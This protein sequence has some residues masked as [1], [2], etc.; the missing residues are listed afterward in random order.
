MIPYCILILISFLS[1]FIAKSKAKGKY[2]I[3][4]GDFISNN[5]FAIPVFFFTLWLLLACRSVEVGNDT[6]NYKL[7]FYGYSNQS[8]EEIFIGVETLFKF[9][10]WIIGKYTDSY[11]V[12]LAI[13]SAI[14][15]V[16]ILALYIQDKRHSYLK[17]ILFC[18]MSIFVLLFSG[19]RQAIALSIGLIAFHF[20]KQKKPIL[21]LLAVFFAMGFHTSSFMLFAMYPVYYLKT[22]KK[23]LP[24]I[25]LLIVLIFI[26]NKPIFDF[27]LKIM[28]LFQTRFD[29]YQSSETG[30]I[31]MIILFVIFTVFAY[32]I[33]DDQKVD[34]EFVG[35]RNYIVMATMLQCFAPLHTLAMRMNYYYI[36]FL[37]IVIPKVLVYTEKKW[38]Q[39]SKFADIVLC[40]FFTMYF[41]VNLISSM[42]TGGSLN[43][44]PYIPFWK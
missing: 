32:V 2:N 41:F 28:A 17:I 8:L 33:P 30:A 9:L 13:V 44:V 21:F 35:M 12:Y 38:R 3:G 15:L 43:T 39:V 7:F 34:K 19:I 42:K 25:L 26:F 31:T 22:Q 18:N 1:S 6:G 36:I 4:V 37:P 14:I 40:V 23:H 24:F 20:V 16:P 10:N 27:L 11:Q 5:N 29:E